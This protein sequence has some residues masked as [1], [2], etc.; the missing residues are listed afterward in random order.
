MSDNNA[1]Q[2]M[3]DFIAEFPNWDILSQ[4][5]IDFTDNVPDCAGLFPGGLIEV[6]RHADITGVKWVDNQ[7]NFVLYTNLAK[8]PNEDEGATINADWLMDFQE[9]MQE[10]SITGN[11]P[12]FGDRPREEQITAQNGA[13][14]SADDEGT[15]IYA[16]QIAVNFVKEF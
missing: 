6:Q 8:S 12:V 13:I 7:Y 10:Q 15:A 5:T 4:L 11:A 14:Y 9:W 3:R 16:I 2:K 1:L